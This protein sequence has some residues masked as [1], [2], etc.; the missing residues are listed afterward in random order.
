VWSF[1][2][3]L[4]KKALIFLLLRNCFCFFPPPQRNQEKRKQQTEEEEKPTETSVEIMGETVFVLD[5]RICNILRSLQLSR[6]E[7]IFRNEEVD[8]EVFVKVNN[9]DLQ[10]IGLRFGPRKKLL[11]YLKR[12]T[13]RPREYA[14]KHEYTNPAKRRKVNDPEDSSEEERNEAD[15]SDEDMDEEEL[16]SRR[17]KATPAHKRNTRFAA[18]SGLD[19]Q[20]LRNA[21]VSFMDKLFEGF[22]RDTLA[23]A[24]VAH[25][26]D[27][28]AT[29][30]H[31]LEDIESRDDDVAG[32]RHDKDLELLAGEA[33]GA[34]VSL[35]PRNSHRP[36]LDY[37]DTENASAEKE[38]EAEETDDYRPNK[39]AKKKG[40][41]I[42]P[43]FLTKR[44]PREDRESY[45]T[46][47]FPSEPMEVIQ[48]TLQENANDLQE[49]IN[50]LLLAK[51]QKDERALRSIKRQNGTPQAPGPE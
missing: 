28:N 51:E 19:A 47:M 17:T 45:L 21:I 38:G 27:I 29:I 36:D 7:D 44:M 26:F 4:F 25:S 15:Y 42:L 1:S 35:V 30:D 32:V 50:K 3:T 10:E 23:K 13:G 24:L 34:E 37:N 41:D 16:V 14:N 31:L 33:E 46:S 40:D 9:E 18:H 43:Y 8:Y 20:H 2:W 22:S 49:S 11:E 6:Y 39:R 5:E 48:R 12:Y